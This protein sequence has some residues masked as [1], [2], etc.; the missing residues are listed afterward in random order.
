MTYDFNYWKQDIRKFKECFAK[1]FDIP[2]CDV[3]IADNP[4]RNIPAIVLGIIQI[5]SQYLNMLDIHSNLILS[6]RNLFQNIGDFSCEK[7]NQEKYEIPNY[8]LSSESFKTN[9]LLNVIQVIPID[10]KRRNVAALI[11]DLITYF[12]LYHEMGHAR[13]IAYTPSK[14][15]SSEKIQVDKLDNQAMEVDADIFAINWLLRTTLINYNNFNSATSD[16]TRQELITFALYSVF[17]LFVISDDNKPIIN[18]NADYPH[19]V[20]R[21]EII[22]S[23]IKEI[24][25]DNNF[26]FAEFE[27]ILKFVLP[28]LRKTITFH[29]GLDYRDYFDKFRVE[30]LKEAKI[31]IDASLKKN[32]ALNFNRPHHPE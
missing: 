13:Q 1:G 21:L 24:L 23:F 26:T 3:E 25:L 17:L 4:F 10:E 6:N 12:V 11:R 31:M 29:F 18:S 7:L 30:E 15:A 2:H 14:E 20:V 8:L 5:P 28:E 27:E 22:S 9:Y 19:P 16:F 32:P